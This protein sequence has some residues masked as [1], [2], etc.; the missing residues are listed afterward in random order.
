MI[1][2]RLTLL[3]TAL[4]LMLCACTSLPKST[5]LSPELSAL[6]QRLAQADHLDA[7]F[8]SSKIYHEI[9]SDFT[10][11]DIRRLS[12]R[13]NDMATVILGNYLKYEGDYPAAAEVYLKACEAGNSVGCVNMGSLQSISF[14]EIKT[15]KSVFEYY[16]MACD[17][18][19][20]LG[21][22]LL[23]GLYYRGRGVEKSYETAHNLWKKSCDIGNYFGCN[24][25]GTL[26]DKGQFVSEDNEKAEALFQY[27]CDGGMEW[28]CKN[29]K[30]VQRE[31]KRQGS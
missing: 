9:K 28:G 10:L 23:G 5:S 14:F 16:K 7:N 30:T 20:A 6:D 15:D 2:S 26:Y 27:S 3:F 21:C 4:G 22:R 12:D 29:L 18:G 11:Q 1:L 25:L 13:G 17:V 19:N 31:I 24:D 8:R